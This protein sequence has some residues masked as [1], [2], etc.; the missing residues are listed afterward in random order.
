MKNAKRTVRFALGAFTLACQA[1]SFAESSL[2]WENPE[3]FQIN[4]EAPR[5]SFVRYQSEAT[6]LEGEIADSTYVKS[7][8]G[9]WTFNWSAKP[10]DRPVGFESP[11]FD[12]SSWGTIPVPSNWELEGHGIPIYANLVY[13]FPKNPP[14]IDHADNPVGS[15]RR[16]FTIPENWDG[17]RVYLSFGAVRSAM[18]IWLNGESIGYSEG[19]KTEAE[20]DITDALQEGENLLAVE[21]YRWSDASYLEDQDFWRLSGIER[22]VNLY[23]TNPTTLADFRIIADLDETYR[24]GLFSASLKL[25]NKGDATETIEVEGKLLDGDKT[26]ASFKTKIKVPANGEA[27][28]NFEKKLPKVRKWTA[29]TPELYTL[30][31]KTTPARGESEY[32]KTRVGFRK[33]E[34]KNSQFLVNGQPVYLKGVNLHDHDPVTGHVVSEEITLLD[35]RIMKE[36]NINAIRCS[37]YPKNPYFYELCDEYGFYVVDEANIE[38]HGMGTTNQGS[39]DESIHPAYLPEWADAHLDRVQRMYHRSKN[40]PSIIIWSLGNEAGNG[41]NHFANYDWLKAQDSTRPVQY[42]GATNH[43]NSDL[44]VPMY[45][46]IEKTEQYV[47]NNPTRPFIMCEYAHAMGNSVGNLQDYWNVFE[48]YPSAQGGFIW[49]WVDQGILAQNEE[50]VPYWA[51]GGDL[52]SAHIRHDENFCLNGI[53]NADRSPHPA[54]FEV[55][56]VYQHIKFRDF[57][58]AS[59]SLE[60]Y[61][62]Y[63]F[64]NLSEFDLFYTLSKEGRTVAMGPLPD[65]ELAPT[66]ATR[67]ALPIG[68]LDPSTEWQLT[69]E[70]KTKHADPL[71][72]AGHTLAAE[73]FSIGSYSAEGFKKAVPGDV[74]DIS[75]DGLLTL[76]NKDFS[77]RFDSDTGFPVSLVY[78]QKSILKESSR[79]NFWR[80]PTDNDY[81]FRMPTEW[82]AWKE[83]GLSP[84]LV[85]LKYKRHSSGSVSVHVGYKLPVVDAD[86]RIDYTVNRNGEILVTNKLVGVSSDL[87]NLPRFG[88]TMILEESYAQAKYYGRGPFE[89]YQDRNTAAFLAQYSSSVEDLGFAY[90]RPQENGY[91]T[92]VRWVEF[93]DASGQGIRIESVDRPLG[94]NARHQYDSDFDAGDKKSQT[95]MSDIKHRPLVSVN[96]DHSQMGVGGDT[97]W[98]ELPHKQY[99]LAPQD[100]EYSYIIRPVR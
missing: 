49:D 36:N 85:S 40:H 78:G 93:L 94:F 5:A 88:N 35:L 7:L 14:F 11:D 44:Q 69:L 18:Y 58:P 47:S 21:V 4:R 38:I 51:Y 27:D 42:E 97:S 31:L 2:E 77:I 25:T 70:A 10:A 28:F 16:T 33:V 61:N 91:R 23:A 76:S 32:T 29:E 80:A 50:G 96:I 12:V 39:F 79:A 54:L 15:Y 100:Y 37:H 68:D 90:A 6:A 8:N 64:T 62:G 98:G 99:R 22:D 65:L 45:W 41:Q 82:K 13:P 55:K 95:H 52:G 48:K 92:D 67:V 63:Y 73:Q 43:S 30:Q 59:K 34:I 74:I 56:K 75:E 72:K 9:D 24:D 86:F 87:P 20:F 19:S 46:N 89:N 17:K 1:T 57:D 71:L 26:A 66:Q 60:I 53:V 81:G 3:I 84:K 83:A